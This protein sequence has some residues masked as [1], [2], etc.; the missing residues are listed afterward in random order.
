MKKNRLKGRKHSRATLTTNFTSGIGKKM[1]YRKDL[2]RYMD[3]NRYINVLE[4]M[5]HIKTFIEFNQV[6][7]DWDYATHGYDDAFNYKLR[8]AYSKK[9][10]EVLS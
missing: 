4:Y 8:K 9:V 2:Q 6:W 1:D 5:E 10:H 7:L 3:E